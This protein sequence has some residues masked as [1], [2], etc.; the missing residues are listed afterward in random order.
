MNTSVAG[1][2]QDAPVLPAVYAIYFSNHPE[3]KYYG[4][5]KNLRNRLAG[6]AGSLFN[7]KHPSFLLQKDFNLY[8]FF[9]LRYSVIAFVEK[10]QLLKTEKECII[11]D[12]VSYNHNLPLRTLTEK[13][14]LWARSYKKVLEKRKTLPRPKSKYKYIT[15]FWPARLWKAQPNI[16]MPY[17]KVKQIH[18]GYFKDEE[19]AHVAIEKYLLDNKSATPIV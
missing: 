10:E 9:Y 17:G 13:R 6:H 16:M 4:S 7:N 2:Y 8:G 11:N 19:K 5:T 14:A 3:K 12:K 18:I 1:F 15:W